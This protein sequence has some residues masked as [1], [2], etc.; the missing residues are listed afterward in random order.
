MYEHLNWL[1]VPVALMAGDKRCKSCAAR[2]P[3][4]NRGCHRRTTPAKGVERASGH[5]GNTPPGD[6]PMIKIFLALLTIAGCTIVASSSGYGA[7]EPDNVAAVVS[8]AA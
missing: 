3:D 4:S 7:M 1:G 2:L 6:L 5:L 8:R